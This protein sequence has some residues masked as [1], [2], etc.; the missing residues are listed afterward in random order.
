MGQLLVLQ[1]D[2]AAGQAKLV[3]SLLL[4]RV[5]GDTLASAEV[6]ERL[7]WLA[8][9]Q[10]DVLTACARLEESLELY[11]KLE[12]KPNIAGVL[13]TLGEVAIMQEDAAWA[14]ALLEESRALN[15]NPLIP[16]TL[17]WTLNHLGHVA[18]FQGE[19]GRAAQL[20]EESLGL[21][22]ELGNH[23]L[24]TAQALQ[25]LG[26][27]ALAQGNVAGAGEYLA[28]A[29]AQFRDLG[30]RAGV[31]WCLA[32]LGSVAALDEDPERAARL[33]GAAERLRQAIGCRTAPATRAT[34]ERAVA[35]ARAQLGEE[36]F[37]AAWEGGRA[38]TVEQAIAEAVGDA[39]E[40][41]TT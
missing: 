1:S 23:W 11:R 38:L 3:E 25:C 2:Y 7:G 37:E 34:Y 35:A 24:G 26:E 27:C 14:T 31:S 19:Y 13:N 16:S 9:E 28:A 39:G 17:A 15:Q 41:P 40:S 21:F 10:G 32:G 30:D 29:L 18:Q 6:L 8:R 22:R 12:P 5:L 36:A 33:W 20:H 4:Y